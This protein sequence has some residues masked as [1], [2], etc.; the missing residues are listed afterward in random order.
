MLKNCLAT[1]V[2]KVSKANNLFTQQSPEMQKYGKQV[3]SDAAQAM[4]DFD[5]ALKEFD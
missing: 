1:Y 5:N 2:D 3:A 4:A